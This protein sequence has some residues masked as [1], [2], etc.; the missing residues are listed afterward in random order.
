[1]DKPEQKAKLE[2]RVHALIDD[3]LFKAFWD[4]V[5]HFKSTDL[6]LCF[7]ESK[8]TDPV[9]IYVRE[10]LIMANDAPDAFR[11]KLNK[12]ARDAASRLTASE[13]TFWFIPMFTDGEMAC[14]AINA[15]LIGPCGTA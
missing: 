10:K 13:T 2:A 8:E 7:D 3:R 15:K 6:V 14:V 9:S 4:A 11:K 1:M 5:A 12:P